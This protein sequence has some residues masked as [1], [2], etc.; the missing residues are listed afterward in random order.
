M[1]GRNG[2]HYPI[3][4]GARTKGAKGQVTSGNRRII[5]A[6][7]WTEH[8]QRKP[9]E[10]HVLI[11]FEG[12]FNNAARDRDQTLD[13]WDQWRDDLGLDRLR[14]LLFI[15]NPVGHAASSFQQSTKMGRHKNRPEDF[16]LKFYHRPASVRTVIEAIL[17]RENVELEVRNYDRWRTQLRKVAADWL[18]VEESDLADVDAPSVNRSLTRAELDYLL[19]L[20]QFAPKLSYRLANSFSNAMPQLQPFK[21]LPSEMVQAA[22]LK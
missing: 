4:Y 19:R 10:L 1:L 8:L 18:G 15:R 17:A 5:D 2:I 3:S 13:E 20:N 11:S 14:I 12:L 9:G 22:M 16:F 21:A 6:E 7:G